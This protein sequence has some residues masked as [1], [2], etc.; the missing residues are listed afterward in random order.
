MNLLL[1]L[2]NSYVFGRGSLSW[3]LRN[4]SFGR[5]L[6]NRSILIILSIVDG[7][8]RS[9]IVL[10]NIAGLSTYVC[11]SCTFVSVL[12]HRWLSIRIS[13]GWRFWSTDLFNKLYLTILLFL[14][15]SCCLF[16]L[17]LCWF[18][19]HLWVLNQQRFLLI[20]LLSWIPS[21]FCLV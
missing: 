20:L 16:R 1:R 21:W 4:N 10:L 17:S 3:V 8:W 11:Y 2:H 9:V 18:D 14:H 6:N 15:Q 5:S 13:V 7:C 12:S 19:Y